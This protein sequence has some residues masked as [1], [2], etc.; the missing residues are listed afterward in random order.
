MDRS[1]AAV[2]T[3]GSPGEIAC[4]RFINRVHAI[5]SAIQLRQ[6]ALCLELLGKC[7]SARQ[8]IMLK[9]EMMHTLARASQTDRNIRALA[10]VHKD[11]KPMIQ[12]DRLRRVLK[13][14]QVAEKAKVRACKREH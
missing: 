6:P 11:M 7:E 5:F 10:L 1:E 12:A 2:E 14:R 4:T 3:D 9:D 13:S 8:V